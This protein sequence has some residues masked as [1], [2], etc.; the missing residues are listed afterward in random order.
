M[1]LDVKITTAVLQLIH[2]R[3]FNIQSILLYNYGLMPIIVF[4][5]LNNLAVFCSFAI[6][7][8]AR[9]K[10]YHSINKGSTI[11]RTSTIGHQVHCD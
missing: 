5:C 8:I 4:I 1:V 10:D 6:L 3:P 2:S 7:A 9:S 11:T